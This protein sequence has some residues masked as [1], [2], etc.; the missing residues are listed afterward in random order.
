MAA[1]LEQAVQKAV[2]SSRTV[3]GDERTGS[4]GP[5]YK[6]SD[7][8]GSVRGGDTVASASAS[9]GAGGQRSD[10]DETARG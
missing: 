10:S 2:T 3:C 9:R 8:P 7:G 6:P 5:K 4:R 1:T